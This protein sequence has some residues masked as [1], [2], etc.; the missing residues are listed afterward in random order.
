MPP[1]NQDYDLDFQ[2]Q[3]GRIAFRQCNGVDS[4][5]ASS[6]S[7][8]SQVFPGE[9]LATGTSDATLVAVRNSTD[10]GPWDADLIDASSMRVVRRLGP[11]AQAPVCA[12][13][14]ADRALAAIGLTPEISQR[15][16]PLEDVFEIWDVASARR[17]A[18]L[19][20]T[21]PPLYDSR[22]PYPARCQIRFSPD[23]TRVATSGATV[24][25]WSSGSGVEIA[26]DARQAGVLPQPIAF[27]P[28]GSELAIGRD[29]GF[30]DLFDV[31]SGALTHFDGA[32][33]VRA[34]SMTAGERRE[35][36]YMTPEQQVRAIAFSP[37]G[38][39]IASVAGHTVGLW[40]VA[41]HELTRFL[42]G[43]PNA[44]VSLAYSPDNR[45][46]YSADVAGQVRGWDIVNVGA[47]KTLSGSLD[48]QAI[49]L[50]SDGTSIGVSQVDGEL[51]VW[52]LADFRKVILRTGTGSRSLTTSTA[53][54]I[55]EDGR[56]VYATELDAVGTI[57]DWNVGTG[58]TTAYAL[59][60]TV[61]TGCKFPSPRR[62]VDDFKLSPNGQFLA[63]AQG[64]CIVV[65]D[66]QTN[67]TAAV[68]NS[69]ALPYPAFAFLP[70]GQLVIAGY[71]PDAR[72]SPTMVIWD[73][74]A[75]RIVRSVPAPIGAQ[76]MSVALSVSRDGRRIAVRTFAYRPT[77]SPADDPSVIFIW[78]GAL[79][80]EL[81]RLTP[82]VG[83]G[84]MAFSPDGRRLATSGTDNIVRVWDADMFQLVLLL[85]DN[86]PHNPAQGTGLVFTPD[87]RLIVGRT[88]GGLT[89]WESRKSGTVSAQVS[90]LPR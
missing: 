24:H 19:A 81:G 64:L 3:G 49:A 46:L 10:S 72:S 17:V 37:N 86:G 42:A 36:M 26:A 28:R 14:S 52:R 23:G 74:R 13:L 38:S 32:G 80:H 58:Q 90:R 55:S 60:A 79:A 48:P 75:N 85:T 27:S 40:D 47:V 7:V 35:F 73:W 65:R 2:A 6:F 12:A 5:D 20:P 53:I 61:E 29:S 82:P 33:L 9:V 41:T 89:I 78:D 30:V 39:Q 43:N 67:R 16:E 54:A 62:S 66:L 51:S 88:G 56:H 84:C 68:L 50:S 63:Y 71:Q 22:Y 69:H 83:L 87:E 57:R 18:R 45:R 44:V 25:V 70:D 77:S 21:R 15:A 31:A 11:Y 76:Q 8:A 34:T 59:N 4:W 1:V